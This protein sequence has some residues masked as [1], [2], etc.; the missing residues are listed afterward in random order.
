MSRAV[1]IVALSA[2]AAACAAPG[3]APGP[4]QAP[5][6]AAERGLR[7]AQRACAGCHSIEASGDSPRSSAPAF[8]TLRMRYTPVQLERRFAAISDRGHYEMPP[9]YIL[10]TEAKDLAAYI[11]SLNGG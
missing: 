4:G 8:G 2:L 10:P 7:F 9:I 3:P 1:L 6:P 5:D 11:E